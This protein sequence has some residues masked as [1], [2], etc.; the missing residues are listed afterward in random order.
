MRTDVNL[1]FLHQF[2][3]AAAA[4][5]CWPRSVRAPVVDA[6]MAHLDREPSDLWR[7]VVD[8]LAGDQRQRS[9][10]EGLRT[11]GARAGGRRAMHLPGADGEDLPEGSASFL[12]PADQRDSTSV[13]Y[14]PSRS[15]A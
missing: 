7:T 14:I 11:Q 13:R 1:L 12:G 2:Q 10:V 3:T 4:Q 9:S 8:L 15:R 6:E 5:I